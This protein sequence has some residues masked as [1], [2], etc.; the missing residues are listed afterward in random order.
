MVRVQKGAADCQWL[1]FPFDSSWIHAKQKGL[2]SRFVRLSF[3]RWDDRTVPDKIRE[4]SAETRAVPDKI[5]E[6]SA[7]T[8]AVLDEIREVSD[9]IR[10]VLGEISP[11]LGE[12]PGFGQNTCSFG[13]D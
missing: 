9:K 4:V 6:V 11:V 7:E 13:Q 10:V 12:T 3:G 8:R 1:S 5:R 2:M